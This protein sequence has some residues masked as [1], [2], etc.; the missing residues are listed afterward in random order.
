MILFHRMPVK[1]TIMAAAVRA[2]LLEQTA[3]Q[4]LSDAQRAGL[5]PRHIPGPQIRLIQEW[6]V[7]RTIV[8]G[9]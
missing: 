9:P 7:C 2:A 5:T 4:L 3:S 6:V 1:P 8:E